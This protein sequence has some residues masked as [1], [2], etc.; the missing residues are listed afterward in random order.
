M[1]VALPEPTAALAWGKLLLTPYCHPGV[2]SHSR[3]PMVA[4][5]TMDT[6]VLSTLLWAASV[7]IAGAAGL[8]G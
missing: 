7:P 2:T 6:M 3:A 8:M 1:P 4:P 5:A